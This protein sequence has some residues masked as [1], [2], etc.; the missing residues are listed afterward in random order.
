[1]SPYHFRDFSEKLK[2]KFRLMH[3]SKAAKLTESL[4]TV[5]ALA[6][7]GWGTKRTSALCRRYNTEKCSLSYIIA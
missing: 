1:M 2:L 3:I 5:G 6:L 7:P 4:G